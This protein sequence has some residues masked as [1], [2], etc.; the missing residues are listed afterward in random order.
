MTFT[1]IRNSAFSVCRYLSKKEVEL[2]MVLLLFH[3]LTCLTLTEAKALKPFQAS[4]RLN[5]HLFL[6][7]QLSLTRNQAACKFYS[8][9]C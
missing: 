2:C 6:K 8:R 1:V 9:G 7:A 3:K 4:L 5:R